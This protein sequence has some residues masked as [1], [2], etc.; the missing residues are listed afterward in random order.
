MK[1]LLFTL[2]M[3]LFP[4]AWE[5]ALYIEYKSK[6]M[7]QPPNGSSF[8]AWIELIMWLGVGYLLYNN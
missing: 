6:M 2:W 7:P 3:L 1:N 4:I 8:L 5:V